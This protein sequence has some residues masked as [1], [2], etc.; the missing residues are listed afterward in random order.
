MSHHNNHMI[1]EYDQENDKITLTPRQI[2]EIDDLEFHFSKGNEKRRK[3][4]EIGFS[5]GSDGEYEADFFDLDEET[6]LNPH[7]EPKTLLARLVSRPHNPTLSVRGFNFQA[8]QF[9]EPDCT[10]IRCCIALLNPSY[11]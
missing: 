3:F 1:S 4:E 10:H 5:S 6:V 2:E 11:K 8:L 7:Q 9:F